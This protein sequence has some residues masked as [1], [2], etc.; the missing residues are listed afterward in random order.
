M[1]VA[2]IITR[3]ADELTFAMKMRY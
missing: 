3:C 1:F 2:H